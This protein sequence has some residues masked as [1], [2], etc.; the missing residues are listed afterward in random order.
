MRGNI[1]VN[2]YGEEVHSGDLVK[3][4]QCKLIKDA[5]PVR[6]FTRMYQAADYKGADKLIDAFMAK[7]KIE[8]ANGKA[9]VIGKKNGAN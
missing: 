2:Q 5:I 6:D 3:K 1:V 9:E 8:K 7:E 4:G